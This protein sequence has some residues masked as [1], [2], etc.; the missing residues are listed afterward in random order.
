MKILAMVLAGLVVFAGGL[1]G[2]IA[3]TGNLNAEGLA[4]IMGQAPTGKDALPEKT[5]GTDALAEANRE[6]MSAIEAREQKLDEKEKQLAQR[7][8]D[9]EALRVQ[10]ETMK[11]QIEGTMVG[12]QQER[13]EQ[14]E[15]M[16]N[17]I[18]AMKPDAAAERLEKFP[19]EDQ[20]EI[21]KRMTKVKDKA[22]ILEAMKPETAARVMTYLQQPS[23]I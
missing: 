10:M 6:R 9:L 20:A 8:K 5:T 21:L 14:L 17:T 11:N 22:K 15:G 16:A 7:E 3:A 4:R 1:A 2:V 23:G 12:K 13:Q 19:V 18:T